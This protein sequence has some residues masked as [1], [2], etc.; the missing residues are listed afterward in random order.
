[1]SK[2]LVIYGSSTGNTESIAKMIADG[3]SDAGHEVTLCNAADVA[4]PGLAEGYDA[5]LMGASVWGEAEIEL[6]DDFE[7][8]FQEFEKMGLEGR[9]LA[10][11]ASGDREYEHFCGA[12]DVIEERGNNC[13]AILM[14]EGLRL[15]GDGSDAKDE[16]DAFVNAVIQ[17]L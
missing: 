12:V 1:M 10:A 4:A 9:K 3:L 6:Q 7:P 16:I 11:F 8:L 17:K 2:I 5:V 14:T 15:E 13:G